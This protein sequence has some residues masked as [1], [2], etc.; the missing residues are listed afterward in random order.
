ML[1][2]VVIIFVNSKPPSFCRERKAARKAAKRALAGNVY[3]DP[4]GASLTVLSEALNEKRHKKKSKRSRSHRRHDSDISTTTRS[5]SSSRHQ[6]RLQRKLEKKEEKKRR[7]AKQREL[8]HAERSSLKM[9][10]IDEA[11]SEVEEDEEHVD[12]C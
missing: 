3:D 12:I 6:R 11:R 8:R 4:D 10:K 5:V 2:C 1:K 7:K 9:A